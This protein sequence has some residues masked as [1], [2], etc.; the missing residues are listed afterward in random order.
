MNHL[1][2]RSAA[3]A[4]ACLFSSS[5]YQTQHG[6][7]QS[8]DSVVRCDESVNVQKIQIQKPKQEEKSES[9]KAVLSKETGMDLKPLQEKVTEI[10]SMHK[11]EEEAKGEE[12]KKEKEEEEGPLFHNLFP[13]RQLWKPTLEYPLWDEN[14]DSRQMKPTGDNDKDRETKRFVRKNGVTKHII[15]IRHGQYDETHKV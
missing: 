2:R 13:L 14:W 9:T 11:Q 3:P 8:Y 5:I 6:K 4:V 7:N 10:P 15:L 1:L 12:E